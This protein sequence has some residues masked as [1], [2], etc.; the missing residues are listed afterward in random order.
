VRVRVDD[1][2]C[3][4]FGVCVYTCPEVFRLGDG[5]YAEVI[6]DEVPAALEHLVRK[7]AAECPSRAIEV[8]E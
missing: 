4:A 7:A 3:A 5:G 8:E 1:D 6:V 2:V